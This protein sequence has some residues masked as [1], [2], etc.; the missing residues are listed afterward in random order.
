M[1]GEKEGGESER[2]GFSGWLGSAAKLVRASGPPGKWLLREIKTTASYHQYKEL[3]HV[4]HSLRKIPHHSPEML[5][6]PALAVEIC[7]SFQSLMGAILE[8]RD[9]ELHCCI[10]VL[11]KSSDGD[12]VGTIGRSEPYDHRPQENDAE[13]A[14]LVERNSVWCCL[15]GRNDGKFEWPVFSCFACGDLQAHPLDF[16]CDREHWQ[17]FY[18]STLVFPLRYIKDEVNSSFVTF[19]FL[20][21]DSPLAN[22]FGDLPDIFRYRERWHVYHQRLQKRAVFHVGAVF[23]DTLSVLMRR[24]FEQNTA[25]GAANGGE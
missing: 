2:E 4:L 18:R 21:F 10:K 9:Q 11:L 6:D 8:K 3:H 14:H 20:A 24:A 19:G 12:R 17:Q 25:E 23:A 16:K 5:C 13:A 7:T 22:A 1:A 15:L